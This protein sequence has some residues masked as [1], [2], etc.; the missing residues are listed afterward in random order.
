MDPVEAAND[1]F[2][3]HVRGKKFRRKQGKIVYDVE[4]LTIDT[5]YLEH[6]HFVTAIVKL[7]DLRNNKAVSVIQ[8]VLTHYWVEVKDDAPSN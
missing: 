6:Y 3:I 4:G 5:G 8:P 2:N 7:R 1:W